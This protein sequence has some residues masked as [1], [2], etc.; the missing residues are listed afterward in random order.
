MLDLAQLQQEPCRRVAGFAVAVS[1]RVAKLNQ[2]AN[3]VERYRWLNRWQLP[4]GRCALAF[5]FQIAGQTNPLPGLVLQIG[6]AAARAGGTVG[7]EVS[8]RMKVTHSRSPCNFAR[9]RSFPVV[10]GRSRYF[11]NE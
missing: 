10:P 2:A 6:F 11:G 7:H 1:V 9:S 5:G 4:G 3:H 8:A